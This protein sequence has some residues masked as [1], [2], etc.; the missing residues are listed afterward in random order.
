MA[1]KIREELLHV[2]GKDPILRKKLFNIPVVL[3]KSSEN[4]RKLVRTLIAHMIYVMNLKYDDYAEVK[5]ISGA[6]I[7][8]PYNIIIVKDK[9]DKKNIVMINPE[10]GNI[11]DEMV[12][13]SSNC[14]SV[15]LKEPIKLRRY[16]RIIATWYSILDGEYIVHEFEGPLAYTIQ[17]EVEHNL[18]CLITDSEEKRLKS[19]R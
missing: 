2:S 14:G 15:V 6:N 13:V 19:W 11:G 7:G 3:I 12:E 5:G 8:V 4:F 1:R 17:H 18:G 10:I 16:K 9:K